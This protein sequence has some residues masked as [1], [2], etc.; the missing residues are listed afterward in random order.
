MLS[1][2]TAGA[3]YPV[4]LNMFGSKKNLKKDENAKKY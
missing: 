3:F 2:E 4:P 1:K